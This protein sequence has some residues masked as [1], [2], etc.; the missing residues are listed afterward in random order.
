MSY[1]LTSTGFSIKSLDVIKTE[2]EAVFRSAYGAGIKTSPDTKIGKLVGV[3]ADRESSMWELSEAVYN[4]M[5]PNSA[6]DVSLARIGEYTAVTPNA[7]TKSTA[8]VYL[9]GTA[10]TVVPAGSLVAVQDAGDQFS[11]L[12]DVT[13][14]ASSKSVIA[15]TRVTSTVNANVTAHGVVVGQRVYM[16]G[17]NETEYN[18]LQEVTV[19]VDVDNFEYE[20][21]TTP[22]TP[23]T[24]TITML[25]MYAG[26][27]EAVNTG[28]VAA[29]AGTLTEIVNAVSGWSTVENDLDATKGAAA[30]TDAAFRSRRV[31]ALQGL[32]AARFEAIRGGLLALTG[33]TQAFV[34]ENDTNVVDGSGRPPKSIEC[35]VQGGTN[36]D[37]YD[38][39]FDKKAA[40]IES[41]GT[42]SGT[43]TDTQGNSH[44]IKF[45]RPTAINIYLEID[46]TTN[47]DF[48]TDGLDLVEAGV[49]AYGD[50]LQ[51][52]EDVIVF[53]VLIGSFDDVPGIEDVA[54]RIGTAASP[55]LDDNIVI[56]E[57]EL[58]DFDSTRITVIELP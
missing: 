39:I 14:V 19:V 1:G 51:I 49:L 34:F 5:Y 6:S 53:P 21:A 32:G 13:I 47:A 23:A 2:L 28:P 27:V 30:E 9:G 58:A 41:Y 10:S 36:Q 40:G 45:S 33:V 4:A 56:A 42:L 18:G 16:S 20:I 15:L 43:A 7:A 38:E 44:T 48:P 26:S 31:A 8:T 22:T 57:T 12:A 50:Q 29:L 55:T 3:L 46:L 52:G 11:L 35:L 24:G 54:I 25:P 37:I 17:A